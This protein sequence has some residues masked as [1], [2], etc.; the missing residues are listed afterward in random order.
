MSKHGLPRLTNLSIP[1]PSPWDDVGITL[2]PEQEPTA[3]SGPTAAELAA[4]LNG[5]SEPALRRYWTEVLWALD[6][7]VRA[8]I[9]Q[10]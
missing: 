1:D 5:L 7:S 10:Y 8:S 9:R 6:P 2:P 3:P 4:F